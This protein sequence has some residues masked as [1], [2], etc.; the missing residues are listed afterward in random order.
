MNRRPDANQDSPQAPPG[1]YPDGANLRFWDGAKWT[2]HL[3]RHGNHPPRAQIPLA[4]PKTLIGLGGLA[5]AISP[6]LTWVNAVLLGRINLFDALQIT[7][8]SEG[9]AW[10]AVVAG[11]AATLIAWRSPRPRV[12]IAASVCIGLIAGI[13]SVWVFIALTQDVRVVD[14]LAQ[15]FYGPWVAILGSVA[16][17]GGGLLLAAARSPR[18]E[19]KNA[20]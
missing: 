11:A 6:F 8:R 1:W 15:L 18:S 3:N 17:L 9:L 20:K 16:V 2:S 14:G 12:I 7:G 4:L 19:D 10:I 13:G 5:L